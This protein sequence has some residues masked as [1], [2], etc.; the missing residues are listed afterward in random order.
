MCVLSVIMNYGLGVHKN[1]WNER[2]ILAFTQ[3]VE[4]AKIFDSLAHQPHCE[5][6][7]KVQELNKLWEQRTNE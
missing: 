7:Q 5:D 6:S 3:L 1:Q 2:S 4:Q